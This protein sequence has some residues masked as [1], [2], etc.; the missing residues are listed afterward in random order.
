MILES[1]VFTMRGTEGDYFMLRFNI[2][3]KSSS[4]STYLKDDHGNDGE[5][6]KISMRMMVVLTMTGPEVGGKSILL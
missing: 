3:R 1:G 6:S 5:T 2:K 4:I